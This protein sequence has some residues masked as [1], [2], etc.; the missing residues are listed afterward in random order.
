VKYPFW[1]DFIFIALILL[2]A[3]SAMM[4][5]SYETWRITQSNVCRQSNANPNMFQQ[6][7][8]LEIVFVNLLCQRNKQG[9]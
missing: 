4:W 2:T 8:I 1:F 3:G 7:I 9:E 5:N 6:L